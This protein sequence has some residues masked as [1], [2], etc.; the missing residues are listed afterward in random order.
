MLNT[1]VASLKGRLKMVHLEGDGVFS[2]A[3]V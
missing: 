3:R 1:I 2:S